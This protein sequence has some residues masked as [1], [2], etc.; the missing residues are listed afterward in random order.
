MTVVAKDQK[1]SKKRLQSIG[2]GSEPRSNIPVS[3]FLKIDT[4][5]LLDGGLIS[6]AV[7]KME[8]VKALSDNKS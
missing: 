7:L 5:T 6:F 1:A 3:L 2:G 4:P 8:C